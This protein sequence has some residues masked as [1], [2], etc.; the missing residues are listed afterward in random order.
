MDAG[1]KLMKRLTLIMFVAF[2]AL[3]QTPIRHGD[4][5]VSAQ[6]VEHNG[7]MAHFVGHVTIETEAVLIQAEDVDFNPDSQEIVTHG[8][9]HIKL[10]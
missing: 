1:V 7:P 3:A 6:R 2:V 8:D 5:S 4:V 9:V 10:K